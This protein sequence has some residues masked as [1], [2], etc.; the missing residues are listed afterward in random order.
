MSSADLI[1]ERTLSIIRSVIVVSNIPFSS[2]VSS[3]N[4]VFVLFNKLVHYIQDGEGKY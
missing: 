1:Q 3:S 2:T 4:D